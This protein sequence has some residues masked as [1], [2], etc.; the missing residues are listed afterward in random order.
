MTPLDWASLSLSDSELRP[1]T[2]GGSPLVSGG[3]VTP[4]SGGGFA[5]DCA[6]ATL[7]TA[8]AIKAAMIGTVERTASPRGFRCMVTN[9]Q[10]WLNVPRISPREHTLGTVRRC[11]FWKRG[12]IICNLRPTSG[13]ARDGFLN[14]EPLAFESPQKKR[15]QQQR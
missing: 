8:K 15:G 7:A 2:V 5:R 10:G 1:P 11:P 3:H 13:D 9:A 4:F 14:K 12:E 6:S